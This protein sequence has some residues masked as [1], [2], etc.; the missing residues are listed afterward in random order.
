VLDV[1]EFVTPTPTTACEYCAFD[2][3]CDSLSLTIISKN[4][5]FMGGG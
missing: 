3:H 5:L 4:S 2:I 1:K